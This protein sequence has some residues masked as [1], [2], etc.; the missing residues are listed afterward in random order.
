MQTNYSKGMK[1][2]LQEAEQAYK[3]NEVPVGA[4]V[5]LDGVVIGKGHNQVE[6][7]KDPT[8]HA[9]MI[10][11]TAAS[12]YMDSKWLLD[13][14]LFVTKEPCSMCAGAIVHAR[15]RML[16]F[17]ASDTKS[18]ACGSVL[19]IPQDSRLNHRVDII[20]GIEEERSTFLLQSFFA[21]LR[22]EKHKTAV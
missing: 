3:I 2:A 13:A 20:K 14:E 21:E 8:A 18:G 19:N 5:L 7:L 11:I 1:I 10:A 4:A 9:E 12:S 16:I 17:G 15:L 22:K 6:M